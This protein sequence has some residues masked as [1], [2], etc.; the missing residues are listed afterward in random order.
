[1][2]PSIS[3]SSCVFVQPATLQWIQPEV[4][5]DAPSGRVHGVTCTIGARYLYFFAGSGARKRKYDDVYVLD[6]GAYDIFP[7]ESRGTC[8]VL[9]II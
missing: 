8:A 2:L 6:L 9:L 1:M 7:F 5:G 4:G 3:F